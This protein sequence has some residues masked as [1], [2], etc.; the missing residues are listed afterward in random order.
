MPKDW[1]EML[2][3]APWLTTEELVRI[4]VDRHHRLL[5]KVGLNP[6][7]L[8]QWIVECI[9][10]YRVQKANAAEAAEIDDEKLSWLT[11]VNL[12]GFIAKKIDARRQREAR[13]ERRHVS[14]D[15]IAHSAVSPNHALDEV[16]CYDWLL[17]F[18]KGLGGEERAIVLFVAAILVWRG[19]KPT[20]TKAAAA[21]D[22]QPRTYQLRLERIRRRFEEFMSRRN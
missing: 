3:Q 20:D 1:S 15:G 22:M 4:H 21:L 16:E 10:D 13:Y 7:V 9:V 11:A 14:F 8:P 12:S 17:E 5:R 2:P 6:S 18:L 19:A